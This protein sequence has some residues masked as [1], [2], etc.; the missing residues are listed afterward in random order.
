MQMYQKTNLN[1]VL[2]LLIVF[3]RNLQRL[4]LLSASGVATA[5]RPAAAVG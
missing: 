4:S 2:H 1:R 3:I 5:T